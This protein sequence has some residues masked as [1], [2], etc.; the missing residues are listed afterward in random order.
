[1]YR[2]MNLLVSLQTLAWKKDVEIIA[3]MHQLRD[4][5]RDTT[6]GGH[7]LCNEVPEKFGAVSQPEVDGMAGLIAGF[8]KGFERVTMVAALTKPSGKPKGKGASVATAAPPRRTSSRVQNKKKEGVEADMRSSGSAS[9]GPI[10]NE[11]DHN[12]GDEED[13]EEDAPST[14][15]GSGPGGALAVLADGAAAVPPA[16]GV[17]KKQE[18][19]S[20]VWGRFSP[21]GFPV[22]R[23]RTAKM[24]HTN[25]KPWELEVWNMLEDPLGGN[26]EVNFQSVPRYYELKNRAMMR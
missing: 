4:V 15:E 2:Q 11:L 20:G 21:T 17:D 13:D 19:K 25:G 1:M 16:A 8:G 9:P 12:N 26:E 10:L 24:D 7:V 22:A 5:M 23:E 6:K 18:H 14:A 3:Q